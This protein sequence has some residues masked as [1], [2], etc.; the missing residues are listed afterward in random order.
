MIR[1]KSHFLIS[2]CCIFFTYSAVFSQSVMPD[3]FD[4][5]TLTEQMKYLDEKTRI[6]EN[7]RAIREDMFQKIKG[8]SVDSLNSAKVRIANYVA[9]SGTLNTRINSLE[10][11]LSSTEVKLRETER[12]KDSIKVI[13]IEINKTAYNSIMWIILA[14]M[15]FLLVMGFLVFKRTLVITGRTKNEL[16][17]LKKEFEAYR[18]K[19]RIER[20]KMSMD[21]FNEIRKLRG[22]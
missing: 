2:A 19:T 5:G 6:Y 22:E 1:K 11:S 17:E 10:E 20:E 4:N 16:D 18:Q 13:G 15:V 12:T 21:H 3:V 8:N 14:A 7:Y 9:L